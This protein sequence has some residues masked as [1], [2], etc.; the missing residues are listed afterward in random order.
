MQ[1]AEER[2]G[3]ESTAAMRTNCCVYI[4]AEDCRAGCCDLEKRSVK[5][6]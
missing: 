3:A 1:F 5:K 4:A 2:R 6:K